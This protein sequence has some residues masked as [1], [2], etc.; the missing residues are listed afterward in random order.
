MEMP[1]LTSAI[2][3]SHVT[4][5]LYYEDSL[6][7][8]ARARVIKADKSVIE[9]DQTVA[10]PEGGGQEGDRG[11]IRTASGMEIRFK[12][13]QK[14]LGRPLFLPDFPV[15]NVDCIVEHIV[16]DEDAGLLETVRTGDA[17]HI[18]IDVVRRAWL[19]LSHTASHLVYLAAGKVRPDAVKYTKGCHIKTD[20]ARFDFATTERFTP[21]Q[22]EEIAEYATGLSNADHPIR[23]FPHDN[24]PEAIYW[25]CVGETIPC[26]GTHLDRTGP[27]GA[28]ALR[29]KSLGKRLERLI[30]SFPNAKCD[31]S[32]YHE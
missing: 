14:K 5:K 16:A 20:S 24:E 11:V 26:G 19:T 2:N 22:L 21:D 8:A 18:E 3:R 32:N 25:E 30:L 28:V 15:I 6:K 27:V 29:R 31:T 1:M 23:L 13:T 12:D 9:L 4:R 7:Y 17:V 10:F